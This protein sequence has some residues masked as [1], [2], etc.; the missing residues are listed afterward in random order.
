VSTIFTPSSIPAG[1]TQA[2]SP[3]APGN[4]PGTGGSSGTTGFGSFNSV[5]TGDPLVMAGLPGLQMIGN[6]AIAWPTANLAICQPFSLPAAVTVLH[7]AWFNGGAASGNIDAGIYN[8]DGTKVVTTG[9]TVMAGLNV[10]QFAS[11]ASTPL[12]AGSYF[13]VLC[14]DNTT[15]QLT[16]TQ[17]GAGIHQVTGMQQ[18]SAAVPLGATL[19]FAN[20]ANNY[21]PYIGAGFTSVF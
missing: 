10:V 12:A 6:A 19:T 7:M 4:I 1:S 5:A 2:G 11:V 8:E 3:F 14:V 13:L 9:S 16:R 17:G 20:P 15:A 21:L 18:A